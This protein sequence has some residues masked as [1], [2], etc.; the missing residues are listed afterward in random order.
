MIRGFFGH[1]RLFGLRQMILQFWLLCNSILLKNILCLNPFPPCPDYLV[2]LSINLF[3]ALKIPCR[4]SWISEWTCAQIWENFLFREIR[5]FAMRL[6]VR[7]SLLLLSADENPWES[8]DALQKRVA[9]R[10]E[11]TPEKAITQL[12]TRK[13]GRTS[14]KRSRK[15]LPA[16]ETSPNFQLIPKA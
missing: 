8:W 1:L 15:T 4:R 9:L 16:W 5:N 11:M 13:C 6:W 14:S 2:I 7:D 3:F 12:S 10:Y